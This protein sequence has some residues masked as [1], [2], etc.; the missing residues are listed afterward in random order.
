MGRRAILSIVLVA[1]LLALGVHSI[2]AQQT[3]NGQ[4]NP[5]ADVEAVQAAVGK[6]GEILLRGTF[7]SGDKGS[8]TISKDIK[9]VGE[10]DS[11]GI[12]ITKVKGGLRTFLSPLPAQFPPQAPGP[13]IAI[14][15]IHFDGTR[16]F[17]IYIA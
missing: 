14:P 15:Y 12:P 5:L 4:D 3:V 10:K 11:Q 1:G 7:D 9:I 8:V 6:G 16:A 13:K 2:D 17:P